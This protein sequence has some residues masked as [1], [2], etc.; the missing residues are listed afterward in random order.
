MTKQQVWRYKCDFCGKANCSG[1]HMARH[2]KHCTANPSRI[3]RMCVLTG[4]DQ[5]PMPELLN[6]LDWNADDGGLPRLREV[7][8]DCPVCILAALRQSGILKDGPHDPESNRLRRRNIEFD[9][10]KE[11]KS[12]MDEVNAEK[13]SWAGA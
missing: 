6:S 12:M 7:S 3:C 11:F 5:R 10:K 4:G 1:G 2:E 13:R 8:S 9:F